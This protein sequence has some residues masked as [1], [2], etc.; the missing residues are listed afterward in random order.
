M[1]MLYKSFTVTKF[2]TDIGSFHSYNE[3]FVRQIGKLDELQRRLRGAEW[4]VQQHSSAVHQSYYWPATSA[5]TRVAQA[6][7]PRM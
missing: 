6:F 7:Q 3:Y 1:L 2:I 4:R 5:A